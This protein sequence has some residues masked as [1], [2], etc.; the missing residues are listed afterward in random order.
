MQ[1]MY[2]YMHPETHMTSHL[3]MDGLEDDCFLLGWPIFRCYVSFGEGTPL[4]MN[5]LNPQ[6][7][8]WMEDDVPFQ[9]GDFF[10]SSRYFEKGCFCEMVCWSFCRS[11]HEGSV[12]VFLRMKSCHAMDLTN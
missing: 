10:G 11:L 5:I 9:L 6:K 2:I 12:T 1:R 4:K 8:R 3:E 7:W